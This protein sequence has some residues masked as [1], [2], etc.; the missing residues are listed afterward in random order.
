MDINAYMTAPPLASCDISMPNDR[1]NMCF[2]LRKVV[3]FTRVDIST[4]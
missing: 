4:L 3:Q 1:P 2:Y